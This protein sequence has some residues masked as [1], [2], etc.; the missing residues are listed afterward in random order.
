[1]LENKLPQELGDEVFI[2]ISR[3]GQSKINLFLKLI[4]ENQLQLVFATTIAQKST[5]VF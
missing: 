2:I 4:G 5:T 3:T 1:M